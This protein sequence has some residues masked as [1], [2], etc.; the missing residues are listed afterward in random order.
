MAKA[1]NPFGRPPLAPKGDDKADT[2]F[3]A[4]GQTLTSW[5]STEYAFARLFGV[6]IS[7]TTRSYSARRA[8]GSL[9]SARGRKDLLENAA[10]NFFRH[11]PDAETEAEIDMVLKLY[12][13]AGSRRNEIA[14]GM[15]MGGPS[16]DRTG[17]FLAPSVWTSTK[18][19]I[20]LVP[21]YLYSSIEIYNFRHHFQELGNRA[22][23]LPERIAAIFQ[24]SPPESRERY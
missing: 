19:Q 12:I 14:H 9:Q 11:F 18:R 1:P 13:D 7:P 20:D 4:V 24:A 22:H 3:L 15:V 2:L 6:L 16:G 10:E 8:Y 23:K 17:Y 5:E 21:D